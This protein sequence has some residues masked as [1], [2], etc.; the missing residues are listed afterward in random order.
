MKKLREKA[1]VFLAA[2]VF[3][4]PNLA[5]AEEIPEITA[6]PEPV[7][8]RRRMED[9][10]PIMEKIYVL[11]KSQDANSIPR[12]AFE[13]SETIFHFVKITGEDQSEEERK[14]HVQQV[15]IHTD[16]NDI[17]KVIAEF[18]PVLEVSTE[19]GFSG[20]L[21]I[22]YT[23]LEISASGYQK[24]NAA[25]SENRTYPNLMSADTSFIPKS[26]EKD[27]NILKL[28]GIEWQESAAENIDGQ[29]LAV[30]YT[31]NATYSGTVSRS[32]TTGYTAVAEYKGEVK[33][34]KNDSVIYTVTY[35]GEPKAMLDA[36]Q[37]ESSL[38]DYWWIIPSTAAVCICGF[39][40]YL[41]IRKRKK[42]Y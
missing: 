19:D 33:K 23:T 20:E 25:I 2:V 26:I 11:P 41:L 7:E 9:E 38:W 27:G 32:Y 36:D 29:E 42:G 15:T 6:L 13:E 17:Q 5:F 31:A 24:E 39:G 16:T 10:V 28:S 3:L 14:E 40:I 8:I 21:E 18:S 22:D 4:I 35:H 30:R 34:I 37:N 1:A 12:E